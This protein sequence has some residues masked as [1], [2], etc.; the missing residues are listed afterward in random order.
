MK[1]AQ[2]VANMRHEAEVKA[3]KECSGNISQI[4][5][6]F[7]EK[8]GYIVTSLDFNFVEV[9]QHGQEKTSVLNEAKLYYD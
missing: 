5:R 3:M 7:Y 2:T 1:P 8:T 6:E 9:T 4:A